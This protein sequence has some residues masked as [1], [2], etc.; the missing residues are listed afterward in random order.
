MS[1]LLI[2]QNFIEY[3]FS[4]QQ[5]YIL[6]KT[7]LFLFFKSL[8]SLGGWQWWWGR[9]RSKIRKLNIQYSRIFSEGIMLYFELCHQ[10]ELPECKLKQG[11]YKKE[12][13]RLFSH[14]NKGKDFQMMS[15]IQFFIKIIIYS[16]QI[17]FLPGI[18]VKFNI[19]T[20]NVIHIN[21]RKEKYDHFNRRGKKLLIKYLTPTKTSIVRAPSIEEDPLN[22]IKNIYSFLVSTVHLMVNPLKSFLQNKNKTRMSII[23]HF[24]GG[25]SQLNTIRKRNKHLKIRREEP[26]CQNLEIIKSESVK[27]STSY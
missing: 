15:E 13:L 7:Q 1:L 23:L 12:N 14:V 9:Q 10:N 19:N 16:N 8:H 26:S 24:I 20:I 22:L 3:S 27:N 6:G 4:K 5:V 2:Q 17:G 11:Q 25:S 21:S 18:Q